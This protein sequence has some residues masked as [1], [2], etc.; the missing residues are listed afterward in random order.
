MAVST[1]GTT[2]VVVDMVL[3]FPDVGW[4]GLE[5][6]LSMVGDRPCP[7]VKYRLGSLTLV[8][9]SRLHER[10]ADR[11]DGMVKAIC[12]ELDIAFQPTA[13]TLYRR[14]DLD[15]GIMADQSYYVEHEADV[16][17]IE[18]DI[19]LNV[20][21][22]PDLA[23]EVVV[24]NPAEKSIAICQ[25]LRIPEVWVYRTRKGTFTILHLDDQGQYIES[26]MSRAFPFLAAD[27]VL[28]WVEAQPAEPWNHW[29]RRLRAWV[30]DVLGPRR[31]GGG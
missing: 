24:S 15:H 27:E 20:S 11:L 5:H 8:S 9:P 3:T 19:D 25:A 14:K 26:P 21:P 31:V 12:V 30:R 23:I 10:R 17:D 6:F 29:E 22:P 7:L 2:E 28:A 16:R 18:D 1:L 13:S 4:E